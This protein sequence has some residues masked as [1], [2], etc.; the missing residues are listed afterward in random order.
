MRGWAPCDVA[1]EGAVRGWHRATCR[2]SV[3]DVLVSASMRAGTTLREPPIGPARHV[4]PL[5]FFACRYAGRAFEREEEAA[6]GEGEM[7]C[8]GMRSMWR[9]VS[10]RC[11]A[12]PP[13]AVF[14]GSLAAGLRCGCSGTSMRTRQQCRHLRRH[15]LT[16]SALRDT[17]ACRPHLHCSPPPSCAP[18][19]T[20]R[21]CA[22][23]C[24]ATCGEQT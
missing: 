6:A 24:G 21:W 19:C 4:F 11:C 15:R 16:C 12:S 9:Q 20:A 2:L 10:C 23:S 3:G 8:K 14:N 7:I 18:R 17:P 1:A 13:D 22:S 5:P